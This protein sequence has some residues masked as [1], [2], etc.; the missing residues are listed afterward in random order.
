MYICE[1]LDEFELVNDKDNLNTRICV[2][3]NCVRFYNK[4]FKHIVD[5][6]TK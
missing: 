1:Y 3:G 5:L 6:F 4:H 2:Q